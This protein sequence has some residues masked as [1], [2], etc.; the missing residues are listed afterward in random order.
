MTALRL[1]ANSAHPSPLTHHEAVARVLSAQVQVDETH[2]AMLAA[3]PGDLLPAVDTWRAAEDELA[4][5]C[6][7]ERTVRLRAAGRRWLGVARG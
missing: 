2:R 1:A 7:R 3:G 5:A 6:L 4:V